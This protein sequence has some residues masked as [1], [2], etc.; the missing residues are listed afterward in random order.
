MYNSVIKRRLQILETNYGREA[1]W[2]MK[3]RGDSIAL[4]TDFQCLDMFLDSY[5]VEPLTKDVEDRHMLMSSH[6]FWQEGAFTFRNR[7]FGEIAPYAIALGISDST[8][9]RVTMRGLYL[10][11]GNL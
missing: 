3:Y 5:H 6:E 2:V 11:I 4:L 1:G 9:G 10:T 7:L 8:N